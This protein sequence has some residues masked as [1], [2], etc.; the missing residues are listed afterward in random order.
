MNM[1]PI[2]FGA[3][4][5]VSTLVGGLFAVRYRKRSGILAAFAAG[6]LIAEFGVQGHIFKCQIRAISL[7]TSTPYDI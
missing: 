5:F 1:F 4:T 7:F 6:V 3:L 2:I